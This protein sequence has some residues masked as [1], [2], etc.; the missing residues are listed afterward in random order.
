MIFSSHAT[1]RERWQLTEEAGDLVFELIR[2]RENCPP[3]GKSLSGEV[4]PVFFTHCSFSF[5]RDF[6]FSS[7]AGSTDKGLL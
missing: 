1:L 3:T 7:F 4:M 6:A 5:S 2:G